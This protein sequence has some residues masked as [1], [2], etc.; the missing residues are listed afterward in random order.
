ME[1]A[2]WGF[3]V[4]RVA[5]QSWSPRRQPER[6]DTDLVG[7]QNSLLHLPCRH[8]LSLLTWVAAS[9]SFFLMLVGVGILTPLSVDI[10]SQVSILVW[11]LALLFVFGKHVSKYIRQG[12]IFSRLVLNLLCKDDHPPASASRVLRL[13]TCAIVPNCFC[14]P[15]LSLK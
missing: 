1:Q 15:F 7:Y 6:E 12:F 8:S 2:G 5:L 9:G 3:P 13:L 10:A 14:L 11:R 4:L